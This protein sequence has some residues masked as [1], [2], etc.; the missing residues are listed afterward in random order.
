[1]NFLLTFS[2]VSMLMISPFPVIADPLGLKVKIKTLPVYDL[3]RVH[4]PSS[5]PG[6]R[7]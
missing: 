4:L 5:L 3:V 6:E 7:G 1:L 2:A